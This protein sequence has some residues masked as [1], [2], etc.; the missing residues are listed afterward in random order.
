M[1]GE[2]IDA[3]RGEP[4][5]LREPVLRF[6]RYLAVRSHA[7][8]IDLAT[9]NPVEIEERIDVE[10]DDRSPSLLFTVAGDRSLIDL[11]ATA[12]RCL[13]VWERWLPR[14]RPMRLESEVTDFIEL[15]ECVREGAPRAFDLP[16]THRR[17]HE[18]LLR[19]LARESRLRGWIPIAV[20][21]LGAF[22]RRPESKVPTWLKDR[23]LVIF[24]ETPGLSSNAVV[25]LL[26]LSQRDT[27]PHSLVRTLVG[28][29]VMVPWTTRSA[30]RDT[31]RVHEE[32]ALFKSTS[33]PQCAAGSIVAE[34][35][36]RW[37][38]LIADRTDNDEMSR[39]A[40]HLAGVLVARPMFT[41][42]EEDGVR[43]ADGS[44]V[45][46]DVILWATGFRAS[47][48]HLWVEYPEKRPTALENRWSFGRPETVRTSVS[49]VQ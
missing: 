12:G 33:E 40:I 45:A 41:S 25:A 15:L 8:A 27:R 29:R 30:E 4:F 37:A 26:R 46:A 48:D 23:S 24:T 43:F 21:L 22:S 18:F 2:F 20:E 17:D 47:L 38:W 13:E 32:I 14:R 44:F 3:S 49:N 5:A 28:G 35:T 19:A 31:T 39:R 16:A 9:G 1:A 11:E 6:D 7:G 34:S 10:H 42:I 36:A